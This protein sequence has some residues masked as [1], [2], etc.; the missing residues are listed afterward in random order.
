M[1]VIKISDEMYEKL[2]SLSEGMNIP[3]WKIATKLIE[4]GLKH[5]EIQEETITRQILKFKD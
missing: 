3:M 4:E 1:K 2:V 5:V